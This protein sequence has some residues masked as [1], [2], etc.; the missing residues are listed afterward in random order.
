MSTGLVCRGLFCLF[1]ASWVGSCVVVPPHDG[2][3]R[4]R[5]GDVV[6]RIKCDVAKIVFRKAYERT[7]DGRAP[8]VFLANWAAKIHLTIAVDDSA[9]VNPGATFTQPLDKTVATALIPAT[10]ETFSIGAGAGVTTEAIRTEDIEFLVSFSDMI[11]EFQT[12]SKRTLYNGCEFEPGT[13]LESD[14]GLSALINSSLEPIASG[15]LYQGNNIGPG[16]APPAIPASQLK[17]I[18]KQLEK[19]KSASSG[20]PAVNPNQSISDLANLFQNKSQLNSLVKKFEIPNDLMSKSANDLKKEQKAEP[21]DVTSVKTILVYADQA[22]TEE[23]RTQAIIN[24]IVKPLYGI[25]STSLDPLCLKDATQS[26][27]DAIAWSAKVS[28]AVIDV[29]KATT[30]TDAETALKAVKGAES[31]VI[32]SAN[33]MVSD[34]KTCGTK[35]KPTN[36]PPQYDPIDVISETVNFYIT[37]S[38]SVTPGWKLVQ[39]T[40]PLAPAF[41]SGFRKDTNTLILAMGRPAPSPTGGVVSS[42]VM[43]RQIL[44]SILSQAFMTRPGP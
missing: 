36:G 20:L 17:D 22:H 10:V 16:A 7:E 39:V 31:S 27:F 30:E 44:T 33:K 21:S 29:D 13:L 19:L 4:V 37:W 14:L 42:S 34:I 9:S 26:Q 24:N 18:S 25:A 12:P 41:L 38:G 1:I 2:L 3:A 5:V 23:Q 43:D 35:K 15:V 28:L 40:A 8:F 11:S 32:D 6:K